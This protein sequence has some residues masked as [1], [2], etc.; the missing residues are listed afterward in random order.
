MKAKTYQ[1]LL[2]LSIQ[3]SQN[4]LLDP[5]LEHAMGMAIDLMNAERGFLVLVG[6]DN[7][8]DFRVKLDSNGHELENPDEEISHTILQEVIQK[9]EARILSNAGKDPDFAA[10][11][12]VVSLQ[13]R[14]VI[15]VPLVFQDEILGAVYLENRSIINEF[16]EKDL[17]PLE[18]FSSHL[19]V[20]IKNA[21]LNSDLQGRVSARTIELQQVNQELRK[22]IAERRLFEEQLKNL[23]NTDSLT[24]VYNRRHFYKLA[25][26]ELHR[27][28][29]Y[30]RDLSILMI[31][32]DHFKQVNDTH[33]HLVGDQVLKSL[34]QICT[35]LIRENDIFARFGGEE[36]IF[37]LPES[38]I[39]QA[40]VAAE[41]L[42]F[43]IEKAVLVTDAGEL[44]ITISAGV[45]S[46]NGQQEVS[47]DR[48]IDQADKA[49]YRAKQVGRNRVT[50]WR[51]ER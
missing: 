17:E 38:T 46:W 24:G 16:E 47:I 43:N 7:Q 29:R 36:F 21:M 31:D 11:D 10:S 18:V 2:E 48:L 8:L 9:G 3:L 27:A 45:S 25:A 14:S 6:R 50:S 51:E 37:L 39:E 23:S 13:L 5:L 30:K 4:R 44:S 35:S 28:Y 12:S 32:I 34:A 22:E 1:K 19:A 26:D 42:R 49:L 41:R 40:Q 15:C 33:G 20:S